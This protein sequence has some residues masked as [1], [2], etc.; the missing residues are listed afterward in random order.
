MHFTFNY[1]TSFTRTSE[2]NSCT[3]DDVASTT[4]NHTDE[5]Y[6]SED[7]QTIVLNFCLL[8][9]KTIWDDDMAS[10]LD[11]TSSGKQMYLMPRQVHSSWN[12]TKAFL[13]GTD[14]TSKKHKDL[15]ARNT[16]KL[17]SNISNIT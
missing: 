9:L 13:H 5:N 14:I 4:T 10:K 1:G 3:G 15:S 6:G 11:N 16:R 7:C 17:M 8:P 12:A 2:S